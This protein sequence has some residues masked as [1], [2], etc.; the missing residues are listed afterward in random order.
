[1]YICWILPIKYYS[2]SAKYLTFMVVDLKFTNLLMDY[3][4]ILF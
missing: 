4:Y 2:L 3:F 1:M